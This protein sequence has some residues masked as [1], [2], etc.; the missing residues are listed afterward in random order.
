MVNDLNDIRERRERFR[1]FLRDNPFFRNDPFFDQYDDVG[2]LSE[3]EQYLDAE[4][5]LNDEGTDGEFTDGQYD[6]GDG[7]S[8]TSGDGGLKPLPPEAWVAAE[9]QTSPLRFRGRWETSKTRYRPAAPCRTRAACRP[10]TGSC[11]SPGFCCWPDCRSTGGRRAEDKCE[12]NGRGSVRAAPSETRTP[13]HRAGPLSRL[14][15]VSP[16]AAPNTYTSKRG[17][18]RV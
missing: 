13:D 7:V 15:A 10:S 18:G 2:D 8:A 16:S 11:L 14:P 4:N 17:A 9:I 1:D 6:D 5:D 12:Q 3:E